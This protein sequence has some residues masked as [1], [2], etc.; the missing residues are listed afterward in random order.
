MTP[1]VKLTGPAGQG[2]R[3]KG[4]RA[5]TYGMY[6]LLMSCALAFRLDNATVLVYVAHPDRAQPMAGFGGSRLVFRPVADCKVRE[7]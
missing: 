3:K 5:T 7:A 4:G 6:C 2:G 1:Q